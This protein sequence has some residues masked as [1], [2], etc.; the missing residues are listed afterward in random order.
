MKTKFITTAAIAISLVI[1]SCSEF[2]MEEARKKERQPKYYTADGDHRWKN[3]ADEHIP[4]ITFIK[5]DK[6]RIHVRV[7]LQPEQEPRHY[8][9]IIALMEGEKIIEEKRFRFSFSRAEAEFDLPD[10]DADYW[11][12]V[13]CNRHDMWKQPVK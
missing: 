3:I 2:E 9:Q 1:S 7:P 6:S 4:E 8:I 5:A 11:I 10:P 12:L 13:R